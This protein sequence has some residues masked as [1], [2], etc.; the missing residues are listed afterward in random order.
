MTVQTRQ[1][2]AI[3]LRK[4]GAGG[5]ARTR[6]FQLG[7]LNFRFFIFRTHKVA[8]KKCTCMRCIPCMHCRCR[9]MTPA[10]LSFEAWQYSYPSQRARKIRELRRAGTSK[11]RS[12]TM[13]CLASRL[14]CYRKPRLDPRLQTPGEGPH[15][16]Y[17]AAFELQRHPGAGRFIRSSTK[18]HQ[19]AIQRQFIGALFKLFC[20]QTQRPGD[21]TR[22]IFAIYRVS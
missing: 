13:C 3:L 14:R 7:N 2:L 1:P 9:L 19:L 20:R 12:L 21:R 17:P 18:Q 16:S 22:L 5:K 4:T 10:K 11:Q 8:Q 6:N 15:A